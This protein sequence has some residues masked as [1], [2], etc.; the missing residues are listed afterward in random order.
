[1]TF[2]SEHTARMCGLQEPM[3]TALMV[4][5]P[6]KAEELLQGNHSNRRLRN[7]YVSDLAAAIR[8]GDWLVTHQG[9]AISR[10]G[11][12]LDGQHR[13][14]AVIRAGVAVTMNVTV[15]ANPESFL[16]LDT[17][18]KRSASYTLGL[19]NSVVGAVRWL[20]A[21][22]QSET[23]GGL[24]HI[25]VSQVQAAL[26]WALP[27]INRLVDEVGSARKIATSSPVLAAVAMRMHIADD[28]PAICSA[29]RAFVLLDYSAMPAGVQALE[30]QISG[31]L[32]SLKT[33]KGL[34]IKAFKAFDLTWEDKKLQFKDEG[35]Q[36]R[37]LHEI[38]LGMSRG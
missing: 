15:N 35:L 18:A 24:S 3:Q 4:I 2:N 23:A 28:Q 21:F 11:R 33:P 9:I 34:V 14:S 38:A 10:D 26:P 37:R 7:P 22:S 6:E 12:L 20:V 31:G 8:R 25:D 13:L 30:R 32:A 27:P 16:V 19:R 29:F 5:T 36:L 17:G 1:M